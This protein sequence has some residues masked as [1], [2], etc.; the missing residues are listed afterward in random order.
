MDH[1][2]GSHRPLDPEA[3]REELEARMRRLEREERLRRAE[4]ERERAGRSAAPAR[5]RDE[6]DSYLPP[7]S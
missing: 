6:L 3:S 7:R 1:L 2:P 5:L 4:R